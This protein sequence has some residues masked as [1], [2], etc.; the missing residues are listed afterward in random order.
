MTTDERA[1]CDQLGAH[2][3]KRQYA[4]LFRHGLFAYDFCCAE[5]CF[6][7]QRPAERRE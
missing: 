2:E 3:R 6:R 7:N 1:S 5:T 4:G